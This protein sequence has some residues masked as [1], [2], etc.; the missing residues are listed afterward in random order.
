MKSF[1]LVIACAAVLSIAGFSNP[2]SADLSCG[3]SFYMAGDDPDDSYD[4]AWAACK[5]AGATGAKEVAGGYWTSNG[6]YNGR[7]TCC[8]LMEE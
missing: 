3:S 8:V 1:H 7:F 2:A 4:A 6:W 5:D